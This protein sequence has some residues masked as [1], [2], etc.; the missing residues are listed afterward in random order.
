SGEYKFYY[1]LTPLKMD[2][3]YGPNLQYQ[4]CNHC[5]YD[6]EVIVTDNCGVIKGSDT[7]T[8]S[9]SQ[10]FK[11]DCSP[12]EPIISDSFSVTIGGQEI[13]NFALTY[14]IKVSDAS[15]RFYDSVHLAQN[16]DL[17]AFNSF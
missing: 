1:N 9:S 2:V 4:L 6:I 14:K 16:T 7:K 12:L 3:I 11:T 10:L 15:L 13:G 17:R 8:V 5:Y